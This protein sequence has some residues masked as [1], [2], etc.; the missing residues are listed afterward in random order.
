MSSSQGSVNNHRYW[1]V[2]SSHDQG[3]VARSPLYGI[4]LESC[5]AFQLESFRLVPLEE[6]SFEPKSVNVQYSGLLSTIKKKL[7]AKYSNFQKCLLCFLFTS[8]NFHQIK[9]VADDFAI[10]SFQLLYNWKERRL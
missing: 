10:F 5:R 7:T 2:L 3:K 8:Q 6:S 1:S 4:S 9:V